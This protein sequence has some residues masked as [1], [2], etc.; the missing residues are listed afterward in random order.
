MKKFTKQDVN[1]ATNEYKRNSNYKKVLVYREWL[2][3]LCAHLPKE[4]GRDN[5]IFW[6]LAL[7]S[8]AIEIKNDKEQPEKF[9]ES[10]YLY[11][12]SITKILGVKDFAGVVE[13]LNLMKSKGLIRYK[14]EGTSL[15]KSGIKFRIQLLKFTQY[16]NDGIYGRSEQ[17]RA[18]HIMNIV[19]QNGFFYAPL[20]DIIEWAVD[21]FPDMK[22]GYKDLCVVLFNNIVYKDEETENNEMYNHHVVQFGNEYIEADGN[23]ISE[24]I[25]ITKVD[26]LSAFLNLR[27]S[28]LNEMLDVLQRRGIIRRRF[29]RNRGTAIVFSALD[30]DRND[31]DYDGVVDKIFDFIAINSYKYKLKRAVKRFSRNNFINRI[32]TK[33]ITTV[34]AK[35][36]HELFELLETFKNRISEKV[37]KAERNVKPAIGWWNDL[38]DAPPP[39][40]FFKSGFDGPF[41]L[42]ALPF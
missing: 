41:D 20:G 29:I 16:V 25:Y 32:K 11:L 14:T 3:D 33:L 30:S 36:R 19:H 8:C 13:V 2:S 9:C 34:V 17:D 24:R 10:F 28:E 42:E 39:P 5:A 15:N 4:S 40:D 22:H 26:E 6:T 37:E 12:S 35:K 7:L 1:A 21:A 23:A 31:E 18:D 38:D 27:Y